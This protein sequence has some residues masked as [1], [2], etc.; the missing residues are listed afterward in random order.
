MSA[1]P[2]DQKPDAFLEEMI[3]IV[4]SAAS[5]NVLLDRS[6]YGEQL[7]SQIYNRTPMINEEGI[8]I[9]REI[10]DSVGV[11]RILMM[12]SN[13][14]A[15]WQRCVDNQEPLTKTQFVKARALY[16]AMADKYNFTRMSLDKFLGQTLP[17]SEPK[18]TEP[19]VEEQPI[20]VAAGQ[21]K[22]T[23]E[24]LKLERANAINTVLSKRLIKPK[25]ELYDELESSVRAFLNNELARIFGT[26]TNT[27]D[28]NNDEVEILKL[29]CQRLRN[30]E[31]T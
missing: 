12:D 26:T 20:A 27:K 5:A 1:P 19:K 10:E 23:K 31:K 30:K 25:G 22:M 6:Y 15:H 18:A 4:S 9:L 8:E 29:F 28:F 11:E 13:V 7:W 14:E 2:K 3:E 21:S 24:Q 17:K 16:S